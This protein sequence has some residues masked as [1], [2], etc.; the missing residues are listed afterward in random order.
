MEGIDKLANTLHTI[1]VE[2]LK[3]LCNEAATEATTL[4]AEDRAKIRGADALVEQIDKG[5][6]RYIDANSLK[7]SF[8]STTT[9]S[10]TRKMVGLQ[11]GQ[12]DNWAQVK[13]D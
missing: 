10:V 8:T 13:T 2:G 12:R 9:V 4:T 7:E 3:S 6:F 11:A 1:I 5:T